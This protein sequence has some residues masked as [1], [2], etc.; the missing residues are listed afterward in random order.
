M[1]ASRVSAIGSVSG[2]MLKIALNKGARGFSVL[3]FC[4]RLSSSCTLGPLVPSFRKATVYETSWFILVKRPI[5]VVAF[6]G[7]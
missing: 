6:L 2:S 1:I 3:S 7:L 4:N 5:L